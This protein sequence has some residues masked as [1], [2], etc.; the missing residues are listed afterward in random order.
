MN[1]TSIIVAYDRNRCIGANNNIPWH[2]PDDF[3]LFRKL[4]I[5]KTVVMGRK[6]WESLRNAPK[7]TYYLPKRLNIVIT[8]SPNELNGWVEQT[9]G[10]VPLAFVGMDDA[11][12]LMYRIGGEKFIVG[13]E[14]IYR[15]FLD[16]G[17]RRV[18]ASE[19]DVTVDGGDTYFPAL[20]GNWEVRELS[21]HP[22]S[23]PRFTRR[24]YVRR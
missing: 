20:M 13:G 17:V 8:S 2:I 16:E 5:D 9:L 19:I 23:V 1:D 12:G 18:V 22:D 15:R 14:Q 7:P 3:K 24:E 11:V 4:T 21:D 6:T 10:D